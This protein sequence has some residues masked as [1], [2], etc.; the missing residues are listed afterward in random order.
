MEMNT[1][2]LHYLWQ[3]EE[4]AAFEGWDFSRLDGR[5]QE[6]VLP[7]DYRSLVLRAL[8]PQARLLDMGTGGG[9]FLLTLGHPPR[10]TSV[11]EGY[12]PNLALCRRRLA[13]LGIT[14]CPAGEDDGLPFG[15]ST[16]DLIIN[17]HE[18]FDAA[19]VFRCPRPGGAFITQQAGADNNRCLSQRLI[20][21]FAP[22]YPHHTLEENIR[23]LRQSGFEIFRSQEEY[24]PLR[25]LDV[26]AVVYY[27]KIIEW[28]FP[29]FSVD[30]C[31][32]RLLALQA[33]IQRD[34]WVKQRNTGL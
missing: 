27:A 19:E 17:R 1:K 16:F 33:D 14:V 21:G 20:A 2:A 15:D 7:W 5:W 29:G 32:D 6:G 30:A 13:P 34:G 25:F 11:T 28:E 12:P 18:S 24:P 31:F 22:P 3:Q 26:G 23:L 10:L 4:A 9:E 8:T